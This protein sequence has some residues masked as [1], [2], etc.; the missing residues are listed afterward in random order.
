MADLHKKLA[1]RRKGISGVKENGTQP[2]NQ[3]TIVSK[4]GPSNIMD[5]ISSMI[6]APP[7]K[8]DSSIHSGDDD[9]DN[10]SDWD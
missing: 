7:P 8:P 10:D 5:R 6:P 1:M 2:S 9:N 4:A 3:A